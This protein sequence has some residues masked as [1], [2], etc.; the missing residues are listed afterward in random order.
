MADRRNRSSLRPDLQRGDH[1]N[2]YGRTRG[3]TSIYWIV[4]TLLA[5]AVLVVL[6][7]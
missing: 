4:G 3:A 1:L 7:F 6:L 5:I 2:P